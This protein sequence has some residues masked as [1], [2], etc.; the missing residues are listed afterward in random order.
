MRKLT[1]LPIF[2][3]VDSFMTS[4]ITFGC[5][6]ARKHIMSLVFRRKRLNNVHCVAKNNGPFI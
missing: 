3:A 2:F 6:E 5:N 1:F 4:G